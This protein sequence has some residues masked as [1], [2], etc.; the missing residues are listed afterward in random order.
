MTRRTGEGEDGMRRGFRDAKESDECGGEE[1]KMLSTC[2]SWAYG[3]EHRAAEDGE[4]IW[5]RR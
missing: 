2:G 3:S 5:Q 4:G 1:D